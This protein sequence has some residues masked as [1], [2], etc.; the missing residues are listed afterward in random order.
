MPSVFDSPTNQ[1]S[2]LSFFFLS[3]V[4]R[5]FVCF[6]RSFVRSFFRSFFLSFFLLFFSKL[7]ILY[8]H[9]SK[10]GF[11]IA[12]DKFSFQRFDSLLSRLLRSSVQTFYTVP[13]TYAAARRLFTT[14]LPV[15][16]WSP[17]SS[18]IFPIIRRKSCYLNLDL[19]P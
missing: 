7:A 6:F 14:A 3:F 16:F 10:L 1:A 15:L 9:I 8:R 18:L 11:S 19:A 2:N 12:V 4:L 17:S 5:L 13:A